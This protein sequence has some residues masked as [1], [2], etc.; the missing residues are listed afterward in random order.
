MGRG[1]KA[2]F[3]PKICHTYPI[4]MKLGTI[5]PYLKE[6]QKLYKSCDTPVKFCWHRAFCQ[7]KSA[8]FECLLILFESLKVVLINM[9]AILMVSARLATSGLL[10]MKIFWNEGYDVIFPAHKDINKILSFD[11]N[12]IVDMV[13]WAKFGNPSIHCVKYRNFIY[14]IGKKEVGKKWLNFG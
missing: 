1:Q 2:P 10:K 12:Y 11:S 3:L 13:I 8:M 14:L 5:I 9:I 4:M 6:I 7:R